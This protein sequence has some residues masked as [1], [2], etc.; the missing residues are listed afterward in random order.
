MLSLYLKAKGRDIIKTGQYMNYQTFSNLQFKPLLINS[1][2][3]KHIDLRETSGEKVPCVS[4][5]ITR[6]LLMF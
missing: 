6:L 4:V 2:H 1:F 3:S 5:S